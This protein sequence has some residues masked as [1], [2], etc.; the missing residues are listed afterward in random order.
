[1]NLGFYFH[2][3]ERAA[4]TA[5]PAARDKS[6]L[7]NLM[8]TFRMIFAVALKT[9]RPLSADCLFDRSSA[10]LLLDGGCYAITNLVFPTGA[11][12]ALRRIAARRV[13]DYPRSPTDM[14]GK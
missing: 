7:R 5:L 4:D 2:G 12:A 9:N 13:N 6:V 1:M 11:G 8:G 14:I 3:A 10:E